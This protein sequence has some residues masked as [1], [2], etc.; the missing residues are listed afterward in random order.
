MKWEPEADERSRAIFQDYAQELS[1]E[2]ERL[3][4]RLKAGAVS[5]EYVTEAAFTIRMRRPSGW[6]DLLLAVGIALVGIASG[7]WVVDLTASHS[8]HFQLGWVK[9][10]A[11][12]VGCLGCLMSGLGGALKVKSG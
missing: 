9:P 11:V 4:R 12:A 6:G 5:A 10:A 2:A 7:V 3:A 8:T 1:D